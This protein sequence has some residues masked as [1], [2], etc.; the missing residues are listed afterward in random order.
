MSKKTLLLLPVMIVAVFGTVPVMALSVGASFNAGTGESAL[1]HEVPI[2]KVGSKPYSNLYKDYGYV[3]SIGGGL[4]ID[5]EK[6]DGTYIHRYN[7][8][9]ERYSVVKDSRQN[10]YRFGFINTF[11][12]VLSHNDYYQFWLGP[13]VG[14][15]Y[16]FGRTSYNFFDNNKLLD[17]YI[18]GQSL[19]GPLISYL[20]GKA[21]YNMAGLDLGI[22]A[23]LNVNFKKHTTLSVGGGVRY[24][25][26]AGGMSFRQGGIFKNNKLV[27][28]HGYEAFLDFSILYRFDTRLSDKQA[29]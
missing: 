10:L 7:I 26:T 3:P 17:S 2:H 21:K 8:T 11:C 29:G 9:M 1:Y 28:S 14:I 15:R 6:S 20:Y 22:V 19:P 25:A 13:Q 12:F 5:D 18:I 27:F 24:G 23:G 16:I 4:V